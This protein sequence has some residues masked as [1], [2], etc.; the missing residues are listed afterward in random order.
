VQ[1]YPQPNKSGN[2]PDLIVGFLSPTPLF[3]LLEKSLFSQDI[4]GMSDS[5]LIKNGTMSCIDESEDYHRLI[6]GRIMGA[7]LSCGFRR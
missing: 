2:L 4:I 3:F 5:V 1:I 7:R 6:I